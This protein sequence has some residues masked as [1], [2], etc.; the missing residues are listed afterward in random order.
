[1]VVVAVI[2]AILGRSPGARA[3]ELARL[4]PPVRLE[5][6]ACFAEAHDAIE[7]AVQVEVGEPPDVDDAGA[8]DV[9]V[10]CS[11]DGLD[12]GVVVEEI[13]RASCRE[14]V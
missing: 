3:G 4:R 1:V 12:G 9:A 5:L 10:A 7:R 13:G 2:A 8:I 6:D 14:R 11:T